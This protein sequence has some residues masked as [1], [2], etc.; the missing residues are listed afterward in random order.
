MNDKGF[1]ELIE[2]VREGGAILRGEKKPARRTVVDE[3]DVKAIRRTGQSQKPTT[4]EIED[5]VA[6]EQ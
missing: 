3:P 5:D 6:P 4:M 1:Q 2:S